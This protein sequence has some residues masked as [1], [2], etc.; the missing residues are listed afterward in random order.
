MSATS[1]MV[2][3]LTTPVFA[4]DGRFI[5]ILTGSLGLT[6]PGML[7]N[8]AKTVIGKTGYLF[9]VT[10][11]G[12]LIMHPDR[13]ASFAAGL[14][15][16][17]QCA[18]RSRAARASREP[19]RRS[20]RTAVRRSSPTSACRR[21][22]GS[23]RAVYPKDEAFL[24]VERAHL[25]LR[26]VPADRAACSSSRHL[27]ADPVPDA[28]ARIAHPTPGEL[29]R[30]RE[31][32]LAPLRGDSGSGEIRALTS[33]FNRLTA[34]PARARGRADRDDAELSAHHR[35][36]DA[37][38]SRKHTADGHHHLRVARVAQSVLGFAAHGAASAIRCS[39]SCIPRTTK[40]SGSPSA[41]R[42][43]RTS[44]SGPSSIACAMLDQ[45]Y[46]W[47]ETTLRLH[48]GRQRRGN[49]PK[50]CAFRA[51]SASASGWRSAC[52]S[53]RAPII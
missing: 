32:R 5:A 22:I 18:L 26:L 46:V 6:K 23:S 7:G 53:W 34:P 14:R 45:H 10:A 38:S 24:A 50:C 28:A 43:H 49:A 12:K 4:K 33:A 52:T 31:E 41:S 17:D 47:F 2:L 40:S 37:T 25:A 16:R 19:R 42:P 48:A 36:L 9:I 29:H 39:S 3:V 44:R 27:A 30:R 15:R 51:T 8:I 21:R 13:Q 20:T 11:D 1:N 35:E